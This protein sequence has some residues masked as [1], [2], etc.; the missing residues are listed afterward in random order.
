MRVIKEKGKQN[1]IVRAIVGKTPTLLFITAMV[2]FIFVPF[3]VILVTS[4]REKYDTML[5]GFRWWP[6]QFMTDAYKALFQKS[7]Y[8]ISIPRSFL[9]TLYTVVPSVL[10]GLFMSSLAAFAFAK[11]NFAGKNVAFSALLVVM[12]IP[13]TITMVPQSLLYA[14]FNWFNTFYPIMLPGMFGSATCIFFMRQFIKGLPDDLLE[15]SEIDGLNK[16]SA[17]L[18]IILPLS[19]PALISQGLIWFIGGY[20]DYLTPLIY[21]TSTE[22]FPLQLALAQFRGKL[23]TD[24]PSLMASSIVSMLPLLIIYASLQKYFINGIAMSGLK[25]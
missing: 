22:M 20:N 8:N 21:I 3:Y 14:Q 4:F 12:M 11:I 19:A 9:V 18:R 7:V 2:L 5:N 6:E 16:F 24:I 23:A 25:A 15:A 1:Q 10:V 17:F 13:G